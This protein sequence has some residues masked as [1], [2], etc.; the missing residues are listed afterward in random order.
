[1]HEDHLHL[2]ETHRSAA[3]GE[4][5]VNRCGKAIEVQLSKSFAFCWMYEHFLSLISERGPLIA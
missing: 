1:M 3:V 5:A 2:Q 4:A